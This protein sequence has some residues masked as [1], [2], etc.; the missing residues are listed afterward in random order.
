LTPLSLFFFCVSKTQEDFDKLTTM[1]KELILAA[2][3][4]VDASSP[5]GGIIV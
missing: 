2:I 5:T 4:S 3:D 1:Q